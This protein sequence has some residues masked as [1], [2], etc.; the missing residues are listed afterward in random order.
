MKLLVLGGTKFLGRTIVEEAI[1]R[2]HEVTLFNRGNHTELFPQL[3]QLIGDRDGNLHALKGRKWDVVID[4]SCYFP[5]ILRDTLDCLVENVGHYTL[6]STIDAFDYQ[7]VPYI[8][9]NHPVKTLE[10]ES[11]ED[12]KLAYG[13]LKA[14][15]EQI[16]QD[17]MPNQ[18]LI[19]RPGLIVGPHDHT[20]RFTYW[21]SRIAKGGEVLAP[22]NPLAPVQFIDV[23]DLSAW[24]VQMVEQNKTGL[25]NGVGPA[26]RL[27]MQQ[28]LSECNQVTSSNAEF[29]WIDEAFLLAHNVGPWV[30]V[31]LWLPQTG[32]TAAICK[33]SNKKAIEAGLQLRPIADTI[34]DTINWDQLRDPDEP[35][36]AGLLP[37]KEKELI[38]AWKAQNGH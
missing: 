33:I 29:V 38:H 11:I 18:S 20:D 19:I 25:F 8:D 22:G 3:E 28:F 12:I 1:K 21:G 9:E 24:V 32:N 13:N 31:P 10:D 30:E 37:E 5:R 17:R 7:D 15:C 2:G 16:L 4:T 35:R 26:E 27:S 6:I 34:R 23:R 14:R 36:K